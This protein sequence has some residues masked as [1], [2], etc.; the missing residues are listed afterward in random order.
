M[1][2]LRCAPFSLST[3]HQIVLHRLGYILLKLNYSGK[4]VLHYLPISPTGPGVGV[5][6]M[7]VC[8]AI[9]WRVAYRTQPASMR[10]GVACVIRCPAFPGLRL[11]LYLHRHPADGSVW[12]CAVM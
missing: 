12:G 1:V 2:I 11:Q 9:R 10:Y 3:F 6:R 8:P 5:L 7:H 4:R